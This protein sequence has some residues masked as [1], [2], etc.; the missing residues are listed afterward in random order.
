[1]RHQRRRWRKERRWSY[2]GDYGGLSGGWAD[3]DVAATTP[4]PT[5]GQRG[6]AGAGACA[7]SSARTWPCWAAAADGG[8]TAA[9]VMAAVIAAAGSAATADGRY[10]GNR[11]A[12]P[13]R[14]TPP[15]RALH[16]RLVCAVSLVWLLP[17][18]VS[19]APPLPPPP[20]PRQLTCAHRSVAS[21]SPAGRGKC[22]PECRR[23]ARASSVHVAGNVV[24][25]GQS[26]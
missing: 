19:T 20:L 3:D 22:R 1:M 8:A 26:T 9:A 5:G 6:L 21:P 13:P 10:G 25:S 23:R 18:P 4:K 15:A 24:G 12:P 17:S 16:R 11:V 14:H 2:S 7:G